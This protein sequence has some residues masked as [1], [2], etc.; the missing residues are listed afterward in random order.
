MEDSRILSKRFMM[1]ATK[2]N[3]KRKN[4]GMSIDLLTIWLPIW[5]N[6][7]VDS[8]GLART[9]MVMFK[10]TVLLK[11]LYFLLRLW[12]SRTYDFSASCS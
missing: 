5:L 8:F 12:I 6:Q 9:M 11:V 7:M 4:F 10:V 1:N 2:K 3:S